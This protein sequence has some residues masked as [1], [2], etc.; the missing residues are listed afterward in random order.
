MRPHRAKSRDATAKRVPS[1]AHSQRPRRSR[2]GKA[3]SIAKNRFRVE[4]G[5][6][7]RARDR[8]AD[9]RRASEG[10]RRKCNRAPAGQTHKQHNSV[11]ARVTRAGEVLKSGASVVFAPA[12]GTRATA[13]PVTRAF[14]LPRTAIIAP[15]ALLDAEFAFVRRVLG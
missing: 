14:R 2:D 12:R 8:G 5:G 4:G 7:R 15:R 13:D 11:C 6:K 10:R 1:F 3:R 9:R